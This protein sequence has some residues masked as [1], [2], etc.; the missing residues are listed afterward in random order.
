MPP[1]AN[2]VMVL[3]DWAWPVDGHV[4]L[5]EDGALRSGSM[6]GEPTLD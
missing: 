2:T 6:A 5:D 3:M 4:Y 1:S